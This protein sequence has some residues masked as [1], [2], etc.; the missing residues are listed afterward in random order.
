MNTASESNSNSKN[1]G[2]APEG[3]NNKT[4]YKTSEERQ[5]LCKRYCAYLINGGY[6][7]YFPECSIKT[8]NYYIETYPVDFPT[9]KI[10]EAERLYKQK[11]FNLLCNGATGKVPNYNAASAIFLAKNI[12]KF[13]DSH[14]LTSDGEKI[15]IPQII[16]HTPQS[17][18]IM[19]KI[20]NNKSREED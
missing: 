8:V 6:P 5:A 17:A 15:S 11:Y 4:K 16:V 10:E 12:N 14:D 2:G 13:R 1:L 9:E 7:S 3:N 19:N 20:I 18:E